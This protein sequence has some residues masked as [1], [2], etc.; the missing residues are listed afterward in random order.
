MYRVTKYAI[1]LVVVLVAA[2][3]GVDRYL[4]TSAL[5]LAS[6]QPRPP[7]PVPA[8]VAQVHQGDVPIVLDGLG[9]VQALNTAV[10]RS[11]VTGLLQTVNFN[12]GQT[13]KRG[14]L[15]GQIDPRPEQ[16]M[17]DEAVAQF[18]RDQ[19]NLANTQI[20]LGRNVPLLHQGFATD[21]LV[22]DEKAQIAE[23][24]A[25]I[26]FD[27][28][29]IENARTQLSYTSLVAPFDGVTG[30][31][32]MDMGNVIH[33]TDTNGLVTVTQV[34]PIDIVFILPTSDIPAV[35]QALEAGPVV[36]TA[37]DQAGTKKLD[38]GKLL[39]INNLADPS[40][41]TVQLKAEFPNPKR[42]LW[43]G[44][45]VNVEL[46]VRVVHD[47][48]TIPTDALQQGSNGPLVY[49]V[50]PGEKVA[51]RTVQVTQRHRGEALVSEGLKPDETV[52]TQGQ[53]RLADGIA[54]TPSPP[55]QV[56][57]ESAASA[58]LLP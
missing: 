48:L 55:G 56:A 57:N 58:G 37:Y 36:A 7:P 32:M 22:T 10:I 52:V 47:G 54:I 8:V 25:T 4:S 23:L 43:P 11:Q 9:T 39:L 14:D 15:V 17:L 24:Q 33:P 20:N 27:Q 2:G 45:F 29:A 38:V 49:V 19:A 18:G 35:L 12:E 41:G 6:S 3:I 40:T 28:A 31:R 30:V 1:G 13:V 5:V 44:A 46:A 21:Q 53:Y 34:Q 50:G 42:L 51:A 16:A 26:K